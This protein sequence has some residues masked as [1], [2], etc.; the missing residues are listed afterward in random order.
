MSWHIMVIESLATKDETQSDQPMIK[1]DYYVTIM[2]KQCKQ[3]ASAVAAIS[4]E[5]LKLH[6][7]KNPDVTHFWLRSDQVKNE[8]RR[9][10]GLGGKECQIPTEF[11]YRQHATSLIN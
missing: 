6:K 2:S 8:T 4:K 11:F 7:Q 9:G 1:T 10:M 3:D 5:V